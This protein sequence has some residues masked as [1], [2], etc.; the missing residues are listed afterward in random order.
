MTGEVLVLESEWPG[1]HTLAQ[2]PRSAVDMMVFRD[3]HVGGPTE[4]AK[5]LLGKPITTGHY[6]HYTP[7]QAI[8][9]GK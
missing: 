4:T 3:F 9:S 1:E 6:S 5:H 7:K 8:M 2:L